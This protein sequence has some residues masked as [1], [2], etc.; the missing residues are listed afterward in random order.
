MRGSMA[1]DTMPS[2]QEQRIFR[3]D[4]KS[5]FAVFPNSMW[6]D[7]KISIG[8]KGLLGYVG[9]RPLRW[10][11]RLS[12]LSKVLNIGRDKLRRFIR[13]LMAAGYVERSQSRNS[14]KTFGR[15]DYWVYT[16]P[17]VAS[18]PQTEKPATEKPSPEEPSP[19]NQSAYKERS[20]P[21]KESNQVTASAKGGGGSE[22]SRTEQAARPKRLGNEER[23]RSERPE[24]IQARLA[25]R[26]GGGDV[27]TGWLLLGM[28]APDHLDQLTAQERNGC[29]CDSDVRRMQRALRSE[30]ARPMPGASA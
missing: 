15:M 18:L 30:L 2:K 14:D 5:Q 19:E 24:V 26:L 29:L 9:S 12:H 25:D 21:S 3:G 20:L 10:N 23:S 6:E 7:E 28:L 16:Q 17:S 11:I 4:H 13:E 8:A 27:A 22:A 1:A